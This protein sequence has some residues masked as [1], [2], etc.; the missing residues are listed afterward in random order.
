M[1][2]AMPASIAPVAVTTPMNPPMISTKS[3]TS[4][5]FAV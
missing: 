2:R 4:M 5:A 1:A 3:D